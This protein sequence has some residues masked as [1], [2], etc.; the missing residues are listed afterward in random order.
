[1]GILMPKI[2]RADAVDLV[3]EAG[4]SK[5]RQ[6]LALLAMKKDGPPFTRGKHGTEYDE[7]ELK[8][9]INDQKAKQKAR[10][11]F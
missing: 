8:A 9:W 11:G 10:R 2:V 4:I 5:S 7:D 1:M 3:L 6:A